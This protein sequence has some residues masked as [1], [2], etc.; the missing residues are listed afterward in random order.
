MEKCMKQGRAAGI[1][2]PV[3]SLPSAYGIGSFGKAAFDFIDKLEKGGQKYWQVLP[4]GPT[5]YGDSPY[6]SFSAFAGNPYFID[7]DLLID[8]GLLKKEE[9]E[10]YDWGDNP[11]KVDY[12]LLYKNRFMVLHK[13]CSR[14][15]FRKKK[16]YADFCKKNKYWLDDYALYM[17]L[18]FY[19]SGKEWPLWPEDI[20]YRQKKAIS[21][22]EKLLAVEINFWKFCQFYFF[23]QWN[24]IKKYANKKNISIIGDIPLYVALDSA[25]V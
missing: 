1:L 9:V 2:L 11:S 18:K 16:E 21:Q 24:D 23:K 13:A 17:A 7:L 8:E 5:S 3:S 22:Y 15:D 25:D 20:R 6:Q 19:N 4:L 10:G 14:S 12:P